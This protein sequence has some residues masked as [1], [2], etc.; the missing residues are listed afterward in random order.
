MNLLA[1]LGFGVDF[2][3][4][5]GTL[6]TALIYVVSGIGGSVLSLCVVPNATSIGA[7]GALV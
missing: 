2:E 7:S 4:R 6:K 3:K 5:W 1:Q